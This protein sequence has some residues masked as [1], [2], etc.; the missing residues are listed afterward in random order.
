MPFFCKTLKK[1]V[2]TGVTLQVRIPQTEMNKDRKR[3]SFSASASLTLEAALVLPLLLYAGVILITLFRVMDIHRQVQ[4]RVEKVGGEI[5]Q[6]AY[7]LEYTG[8][9]SFLGTVSAYGYAEAALRR[10]L[11][12]L[13]VDRLT[14]LRSHLLEDGE[15]VDLV[16]DYE[17][18]MPFSVLGRRAVKQTNR[19]FGRAW[20][21]TE[22]KNKLPG[23]A[24]ED[25][26]V[27]YVGKNSTRYH[28]SRTCHYLY[29][30]LTA[31][32][33]KDIEAQRNENG[34]RYSP[35]VRCRN[36]TALEVYIMP[37]GRH[38]HTSS[39]C[40]AI[41][42]YVSTVSKSEVEHLGPCSYCRKNRDR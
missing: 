5:S 17:I 14:L 24:G 27:V 23:E 6:A 36:Q 4:A 19:S 10:E 40:S 2:E 30:D 34:S 32:P 11:E 28:I 20:I 12:Q 26:T 8:T 1:S 42:A 39:S 16:V 37:S 25:E 9:G 41:R 7:M 13:P 31:V 22:D 18:S 29:N 21:G 38:Y 35:C 15:T 3:V 33:L